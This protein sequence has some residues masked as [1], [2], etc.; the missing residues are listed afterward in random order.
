MASLERR[1]PRPDQTVVA[2]DGVSIF[3]G[4]LQ[5]GSVQATKKVKLGLGHEWEGGREEGKV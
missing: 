3:R 1:Y 2:R 4:Q 5:S